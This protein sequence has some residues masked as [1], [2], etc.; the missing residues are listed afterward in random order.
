MYK[1]K[2]NLIDMVSFRI[3][4]VE[5]IYFVE[6]KINVDCFYIKNRMML[7]WVVL[8]LLLIVIGFLYIVGGGGII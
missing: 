1:R 3:I 5:C 2:Y 4:I 6:K 8:F 7:I